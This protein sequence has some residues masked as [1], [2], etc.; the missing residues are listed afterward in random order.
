MRC[1]WG[2]NT[3]GRTGRFIPRNRGYGLDGHDGRD[4]L[5]NFNAMAANDWGDEEVATAENPED[6]GEGEQKYG[7]PVLSEDKVPAGIASY[8]KKN[9]QVAGMA[10]GGGANGSDAS[11]PRVI[12]PNKFNAHM[13][14]PERR[15]GLIKI[16]AARHL[17][18]ETKYSPKFEIAPEQ[19]QWRKEL[20]Q[21]A[22]DDTA[23]KQS[24][25]SRLMAGDEVP[26]AT[27]EQRLAAEAFDRQLNGRG[28]ENP[29]D[30]GD[31]PVEQG[32]R[33]RLTFYTRFDD[34]KAYENGVTAMPSPAGVKRAQ[35]GVTVAVDPEKIP[36]GSRLLIPAL[37][38]F[39]A[40]GDGVFVAHDT[41]GDVRSRKATGGTHDEIG[42]AHV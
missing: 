2:L 37:A 4:G 39:S 28:S 14:D 11:E 38:K 24:I 21:Y 22:T 6:R 31:E 30:W 5:K 13:S 29:E 8:F 34:G 12:I 3:W 26:A 41:G 27:K 23:F 35:E 9:P 25:V 19:Q 20:G 1:R 36:Y 10:W 40:G 15:E 18:Y 33:A 42:R 17:M 16:E 32:Q 7:Y